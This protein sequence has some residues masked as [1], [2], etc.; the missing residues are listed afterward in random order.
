MVSLMIKEIEVLMPT[1]GSIVTF[2]QTLPI[3]A[4]KS[5]IGNTF[6]YKQL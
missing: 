2:G 1:N 4:D 6:S 5:Y 3:Y